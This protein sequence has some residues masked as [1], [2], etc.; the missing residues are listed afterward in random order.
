MSGEHLSE[1]VLSA[2][3]DDRLPASE[4]AAREHLARCAS[5][6][7]HLSSLRSV[8]DMLHRLPVVEPS[9]DFSLGPR[10][11]TAPANLVRWRRAYTWT[12]AVAASLAAVFALLVA[13]TVYQDARTP[14]AVPLASRAAQPAA[15]SAVTSA[16]APG[17]QRTLPP[18]GA[19]PA[20]RSAAGA[21]AQPR[22]A[23][24]ANAPGPQNQQPRPTDSTDQFAAATRV[25]PLA[26]V[27]PRPTAAPAAAPA[28]PSPPAREPVQTLPAADS[29][30]RA[31]VL[32][33]LLTSLVV[34][35]AIL[36]RRR[37]ARAQRSTFSE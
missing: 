4:A 12:R 15:D 22:A 27:P 29:L 10:L 20:G 13:G 14:E 31:A 24:P 21:A 8:V 26:T 9:R 17:V 34:G 2:L 3:V 37:L 11:V 1:D 16:N 6:A 30:R 36:A 33:G 32:L 5:C 23:L 35:A 25:Q 19:A 18:D 7:Q 28:P